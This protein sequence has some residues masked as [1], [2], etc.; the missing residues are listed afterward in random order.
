VNVVGS[1][2]PKG[3]GKWGQSDLAGNVAEWV[4]DW[5]ASSYARPCLDCANLT[6]ATN[7]VIRGGHYYIGATF[8]RAAYRGTGVPPTVRLYFFGFRCARR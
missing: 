1:E 2:S 5:Y 7:R 6:P 8:L 4:L 3:D